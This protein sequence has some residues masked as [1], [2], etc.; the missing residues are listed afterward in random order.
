MYNSTNCSINYS[1]IDDSL[2]PAHPYFCCLNPSGIINSK[3]VHPILFV[4]A[5]DRLRK[6]EVV[7]RKI[8]HLINLK[9]IQY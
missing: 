1:I 3:S 6:F 5:P 9:N 8:I 4:F 7:F 2:T